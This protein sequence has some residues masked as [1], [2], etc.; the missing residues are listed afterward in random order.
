MEHAKPWKISKADRNRA[1]DLTQCVV[2]DVTNAVPWHHLAPHEEWGFLRG[3]Q[4]LK[5]VLYM[6][7]LDIS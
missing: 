5:H 3:F 7:N 2:A 6:G 4:H 1:F